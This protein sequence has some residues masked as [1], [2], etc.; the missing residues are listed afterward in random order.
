MFVLRIAKRHHT[1]HRCSLALGFPARIIDSQN[2]FFLI[3]SRK[4]FARQKIWIQ[5][6]LTRDSW[7]KGSGQTVGRSFKGTCR[8]VHQDSEVVVGK[9]SLAARYW[10]SVETARFYRT[11]RIAVICMIKHPKSWIG[12]SEGCIRTTGFGFQVQRKQWPASN[13]GLRNDCFPTR[14]KYWLAET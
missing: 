7:S 2:V 3:P 5:A 11:N 14:I 4:D 13:K 1:R 10:A 12:H 6:S 9:R 8:V